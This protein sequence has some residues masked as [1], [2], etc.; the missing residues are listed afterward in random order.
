[1]VEAAGMEAQTRET[2]DRANEGWDW[3]IVEIF[4][5]RKH[6]GRVR[7]EE[8]FGAKMLRIDIP[9]KGD[10]ATHGWQTH[11]YGGSSIFS[12][13]LTD[14]ASALRANKPYEAPARFSLAPPSD[15]GAGDDPDESWT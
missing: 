6:V 4:G 7:E 11:Y 9:L 8:R 14:E 10:P 2:E 15:G 5:H 1:M 3:G 12:F 13:S